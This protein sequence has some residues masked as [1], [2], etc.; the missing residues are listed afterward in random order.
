[1]IAYIRDPRSL[2]AEGALV[3]HLPPVSSSELL[4]AELSAR[5]AFP[6]YFGMN[7]DALH[8]VL[9]DK[10]WLRAP[11]VVLVHDELPALPPKDLATYFGILRDSMLISEKSDLTHQRRI[12]FVFPL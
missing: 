12:D 1:M 10:Y 7:W 8:D 5:L 11:H 3:I 9:A 6:S 2:R 4:L